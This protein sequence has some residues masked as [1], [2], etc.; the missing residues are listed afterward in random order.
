ME[1]FLPTLVGAFVGISLPFIIRAILDRRSYLRTLNSFFAHHETQTQHYVA[2]AKYVLA[3]ASRSWVSFQ[4]Q[5]HNIVRKNFVPPLDHSE[6]LISSYSKYLRQSDVFRLEQ[7]RQNAIFLYKNLTES[8]F[9]NVQDLSTAI[10][11][12]IE[13]SRRKAWTIFMIAKRKDLPFSVT[14][15]E[16]LV[17]QLNSQKE[18]KHLQWVKDFS[19]FKS[20]EH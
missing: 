7:N 5:I 6:L 17:Q 14:N 1:S 8:D 2:S 10:E 13:F 9:E 12:L 20:Q 4:K 16:A 11:T 3:E 15:Y 19:R 18:N